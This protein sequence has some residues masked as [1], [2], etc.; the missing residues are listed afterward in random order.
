MQMLRLKYLSLQLNTT[1][2][3]NT[4]RKGEDNS[5]RERRLGWGD[6]E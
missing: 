1:S 3:R 4:E 2:Y 5:L 6:V